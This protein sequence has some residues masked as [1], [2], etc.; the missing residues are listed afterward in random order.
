VTVAL[1]PLVKA[2]VADLSESLCEMQEGIVVQ[3]RRCTRRCVASRLG[4]GIGLLYVD[5]EVLDDAVANGLGLDSVA[6]LEDVLGKIGCA[7][8]T[9]RRPDDP[10]WVP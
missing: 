6:S 4:K 8:L 7:K 2:R 3:E 9:Y 1:R 5:A 10:L